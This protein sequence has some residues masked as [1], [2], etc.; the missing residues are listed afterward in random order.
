MRK[1]GARISATSF[2]MRKSVP[3]E[4]MKTSVGPS[5]RPWSRVWMTRPLAFT[6][7]MAQV[8]WR[9]FLG[10]TAP[11]VAEEGPPIPDEGDRRAEID[12]S[13]EAGDRSRGNDQHS[14]RRRGADAIAE[15]DED[16]LQ[17]IVV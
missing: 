15:R 5:R 6:N 8:S 3:S 9:R 12:D 17:R 16:P 2:Q 13:V 11:R 10:R 14:R 1:S 4:L 7:L